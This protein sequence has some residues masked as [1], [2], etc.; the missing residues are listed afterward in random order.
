MKMYDLPGAYKDMSNTYADFDVPLNKNIDFQKTVNYPAQNLSVAHTKGNTKQF[1]L[2]WILYGSGAIVAGIFIYNELQKNKNYIS[3]RR[4]RIM[5]YNRP[6]DQVL[7][8]IIPDI[9]VNI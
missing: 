9:N 1:P 7:P 3:N 8:K 2:K 6:V 5:S 4:R